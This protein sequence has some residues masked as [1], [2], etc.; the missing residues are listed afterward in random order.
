MLDIVVRVQRIIS[1]ILVLIRASKRTAKKKR[2][3]ILSWNVY[4]TKKR[5]HRK[6]IETV[7]L[8]SFDQLGPD[9]KQHRWRGGLVSPRRDLWDQHGVCEACSGR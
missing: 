9:R 7:H 8:V 6:H 4:G 2:E 5:D 3:Q 1:I